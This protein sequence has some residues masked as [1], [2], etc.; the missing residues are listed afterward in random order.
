MTTAQHLDT[1]DLLRSREFPAEPGPSDVGSEGPGFHIAELNGQ[2]GD[3][4]DDDE[5]GDAAADQ[6]AEE[7]GALLNVL[8]R[9]WGEPDLF[10]LA[11][12]RLRVE[13][14]E[15]VPDPWR[16]LSEQMEWL[17]LWRNEDRWIAVGLS[18][19][20]LLAVVTEIDPL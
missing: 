9:R 15:E 8:E 20:Q 5:G 4:A 17:H 18:R 10:S 2:F 19:F 6:R 13:R 1:I 12:T 7:H 16:R 11:S 14:D 3:G